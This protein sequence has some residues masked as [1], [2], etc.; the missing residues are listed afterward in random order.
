MLS[1]HSVKTFNREVKPLVSEYC[2]TLGRP[3]TS[4]CNDAVGNI[5]STEKFKLALRFSKNCLQRV[6]KWL[7]ADTIPNFIVQ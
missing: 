4:R 2:D 5:N 3:V 6:G 7:L 1:S